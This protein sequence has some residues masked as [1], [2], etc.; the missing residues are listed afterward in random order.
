MKMEQEK[1]VKINCFGS[2]EVWL[3]GADA[4]L[5]WRTRKARELFAYL[6]HMQ[7]N[8]VERSVLLEKLWLEQEQDYSIASL[9]NA[10]YSI[11][12][13]LG[14]GGM[15][16]LIW[17]EQGRYRIKSEM[18]DSDASRVR[19]MARVIEKENGKELPQYQDLLKNYK[20]SYMGKVSGEWHIEWAE[21]FENIYIR[22]CYLLAGY[23]AGMGR[24]EE[25]IGYLKVGLGID[26]YAEHLAALLI[27]CYGQI[28]DYRNM[29][30]QYEK[31]TGILYRDLGIRHSEM[32]EKA[33]QTFI[34]RGEIL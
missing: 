20:G 34:P 9:H 3:P 24:Y 18:I 16:E 32:L 14:S 23:Y 4:P 33:Y 31:Y 15:R 29:L 25:A 12:Q 30:R 2:F 13:N 8:F 7:G 27:Q 22:G 1:P 28:K 26:V 5:K 11:R 17:C 6:T 21:Y 10:I 19:E